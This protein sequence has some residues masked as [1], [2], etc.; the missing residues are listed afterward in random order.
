MFI[1]I[2][3]SPRTYAWGS[4]DAL[5]G[6]LRQEPTGEPQAELWL[7]DHVTNPSQVSGAS[8]TL[9]DLIAENPD[10]YGVDGGQLP[11]LL[12]ILG[13]GAPL[14][15]QVH[16]RKDQA[17]EGFRREEDAGIPVDHPKRSY[18]DPNH[19]PEL[20]V[21]LTQV[22]ALCGFRELEA[23]R[24]DV[25]VL[26]GDTPQVSRFAELL[27]AGN[28]E[29]VRRDVL[30]WVFAGGAE[31]EATVRALATAAGMSRERGVIDGDRR[32]VMRDISEH[33]PGDPG[34]IISL[35]MNVVRL[36]PGEALFLEAGHL[37]AYVSGAAVEVMASSDNVLR[38]G[39]T[40]KHV[41]VAEFMR[42]LEFTTLHDPVFRP[43]ASVAGLKTWQPPIP[44]FVLHRIRV[45]QADGDAAPRPGA[46]ASV[47]LD[48]P[49]PLVLIATD[50]QLRIERRG[51]GPVEVSSVTQGRS[52]Y[53][54]SGESVE[55]SGSGEAF[56][57]SVGAGWFR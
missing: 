10:V 46:A 28:A 25:E 47:K 20:L 48:A 16:P 31:V 38:A 22:L 41:D 56:I 7:G 3:N 44:D 5:P 11:F 12:K 15:L 54:S 36:E 33:Y 24:R 42:I 51:A 35:L 45:E 26:V 29:R 49:Y 17:E 57:A 1:F 39:L 14:S 9:I 43:Q 27:D 55:F 19:K 30:D 2:K 23:V 13:I 6:V 4:R 53:I 8:L 34:L 40:E 50:G 18:R 21:A 37:H 52:L 32:S